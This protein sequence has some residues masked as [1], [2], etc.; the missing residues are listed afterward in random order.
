MFARVFG[1]F[2]PSC[3]RSCFPR[4]LVRVES[5]ERCVHKGVSGGGVSIPAVEGVEGMSKNLKLSEAE[6]KGIRLEE[7]VKDLGV[8]LILKRLPNFI[9]LGRDCVV[10]GKD[11]VS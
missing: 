6:R 7:A 10:G 2:N 4:S 11:L 5:R 3:M 9:V 8:W 1:D